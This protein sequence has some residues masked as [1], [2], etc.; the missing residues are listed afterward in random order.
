VQQSTQDQCAFLQ[1][2][3]PAGFALTRQGMAPHM[4]QACLHSAPNFWTDKIVIRGRIWVQSP[5]QMV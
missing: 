2:L 5:S 1:L 3:H 4:Q